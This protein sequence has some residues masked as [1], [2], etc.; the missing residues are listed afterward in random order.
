MFPSI[1]DTCAV[2]AIDGVLAHQGGWDEA[3]MVVVPIL[4]FGLLLWVAVVRARHG[5]GP[6]EGHPQGR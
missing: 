2:Q 6:S 5:A 3:L 4:L 1:W